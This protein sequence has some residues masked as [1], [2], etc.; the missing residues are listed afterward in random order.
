MNT[1]FSL[2]RFAKL[3][4]YEHRSSNFLRYATLLI[5]LYSIVVNIITKLT[6]SAAIDGESLFFP[7][8]ITFI[9]GYLSAAFYYPLL[10]KENRE[11][12][13]M[14]PASNLEKYLSVL[15]NTV[16]VVPAFF[17]LLN[18]VRLIG[19]YIK[20]GGEIP[21]VEFYK[22]GLNELC[23]YIQIISIVTYLFFSSMSRSKMVKGIIIVAIYWLSGPLRREFDE[24]GHLL[25]SLLVIAIFQI[26]IYLRIRRIG[27]Q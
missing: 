3:F 11:L 2:A 1:Q 18:L 16:V 22:P 25:T 10:K 15:A 20:F 27:Q 21:G 14:Q 23:D 4:I 24:T 8:K 19:L 6:V 26:L 13:E 17:I 7:V 9:M 12:Y 5:I